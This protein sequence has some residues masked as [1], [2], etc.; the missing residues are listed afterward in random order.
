[1]K[2]TLPRSIALLIALLLLTS[3]FSPTACAGAAERALLRL[4]DGELVLLPE[5]EIDDG[6]IHVE[7]GTEE[8]AF[9]DGLRPFYGVSYSWLVLDLDRALLEQV[10]R[11]TRGVACACYCMAYCRTILDG[12]KRLYSEF[13]LGT[14]LEDAW[15]GWYLGGYDSINYTSASDV[16]ER[17]YQ[18]LC[19]GRP[20]VLLVKGRASTQ[21]Y[22]TVVGFEDVEQGGELDTYNFQV[23]DPCA[24]DF[25]PR[26]MGALGYDLKRLSDGNY[27]ILC[28]TRDESADFEAHRSSYL[29]R[30]TA[31]HTKRLYCVTKE[32][33][34][35]E[36]P[37]AAFAYAPARKLS[38]GG[39]FFVATDLIRNPA[40]EYWLRGTDRDG[41]TVYVRA[42]ELSAFLPLCDGLLEGLELPAVLT[43]GEPL[44]LSGT[45]SAGQPILRLRAEIRAAG[46]GRL[47]R[48]AELEPM[49]GCC[50][51]A[52]SGLAEDLSVETLEAGN[53]VLVLRVGIR[54]DFSTDGKTLRSADCMFRFFSAEF[55]VA[56]MP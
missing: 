37:D 21:H 50:E 31:T 55:S 4:E 46:S 3:C 41:S 25:Q 56:P 26:N 29:S 15:C 8:D 11:Q 35:C 44:S 32:A 49:S 45:V 6:G 34:V 36:L 16:F 47:L 40:G 52:G 24:A 23:L 2:R 19:A 28:D 38:P 7:D 18:E 5:E 22:I 12:Q 51:L 14:G 48:S 43:Q 33:A 13:N 20:V 54:G 10:G 17:C 39:F 1:M 9:F 53:Y 42:A 27:Q 30:C